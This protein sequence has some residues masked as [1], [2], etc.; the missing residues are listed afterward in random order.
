MGIM[1]FDGF[2]VLDLWELWILM[3]FVYYIGGYYGLR[4]V[5]CTI[6]IGVMAF[7]GF[8]VLY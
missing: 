2:C 1:A 7:D 3:D 6:L 4:W 8:C 5:L